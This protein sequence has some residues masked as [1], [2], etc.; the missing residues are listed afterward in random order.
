MSQ[1]AHYRTPGSNSATGGGGGTRTG[2]ALQAIL[3]TTRDTRFSLTR[4]G[5][6]A[7]IVLE[8]NLFSGSKL[9]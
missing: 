2:N 7:T 9:C 6:R 1:T 4:P 8:R 3:Q 5:R